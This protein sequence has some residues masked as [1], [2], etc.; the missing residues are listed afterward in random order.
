MIEKGH[1]LP[2]TYDVLKE[3]YLQGPSVRR[4]NS[5]SGTDCSLAHGNIKSERKAEVKLGRHSLHS[6]YRGN[7][8]D[9]ISETCL[10]GCEI[11]DFAN[12]F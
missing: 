1:V 3:Q 7:C 4:A 2:L 5:T 10:E 6:C 11:K 9:L 8:S 12:H